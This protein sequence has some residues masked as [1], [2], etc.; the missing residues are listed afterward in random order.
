[1]SDDYKTWEVSTGKLDVP[2]AGITLKH[3]SDGPK[4]QALMACSQVTEL[5]FSYLQ[6]E[7]EIL[8]RT[9]STHERQG[10]GRGIWWLFQLHRVPGWEEPQEELMARSSALQIPVGEEPFMPGRAW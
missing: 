3:M 8:P 5:G 7:Q 6:G 1:M 10:E 2:K 4:D 9:L